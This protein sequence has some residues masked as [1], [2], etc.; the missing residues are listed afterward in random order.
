MNLSSVLKS[1]LK[2]IE[3]FRIMASK[4]AELMDPVMLFEGQCKLAL[5]KL[6]AIYIASTKFIVIFSW[7]MFVM[8]S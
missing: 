4:L 7:A 1:E 8:N 6:E 3:Q 2:D 5:L